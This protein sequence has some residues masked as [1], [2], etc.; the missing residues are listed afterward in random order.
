[1]GEM[2][3]TQIKE[4]TREGIKLAKAR[5]VYKG[6]KANTGE[7]V[8]AFLSKDKNKKALDYIKKGYKGSEA[9]KLAGVHPNTVSKIRK[10]LKTVAAHE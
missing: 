9:A 3:R 1:V 4:R 8:L 10:Y 7:D 5:G 2:E 6:R